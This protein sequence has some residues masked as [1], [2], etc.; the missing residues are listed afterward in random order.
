M[1]QRWIDD[2]WFSYREKQSPGD[3]RE[4]TRPRHSSGCLRRLSD[5]YPKKL[6]YLCQ[7]GR[8]SCGGAAGIQMQLSILPRDL[9]NDLQAS[10][11]ESIEV[12]ASTSRL[13]A[14]RMGQSSTLRERLIIARRNNDVLAHLPVGSGTP[15]LGSATTANGGA[16]AFHGFRST[17]S[18]I[19]RS[20]TSPLGGATDACEVHGYC[21]SSSTPRPQSYG[22]YQGGATDTC[23]VHGY[24][25][26]SSSPRPQS[27]GNYQGVC[28]RS[29]E[30]QEV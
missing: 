29:W 20:G 19:S 17:L 28:W 27:Y 7:G 3:A 4:T 30:R 6:L 18:R 24:C 13:S 1:N 22:N 10:A 11:L 26:S 9:W 16:L 23:E 14:R 5:Q 2:L 8:E 15:V 12:A 25:R 21:R